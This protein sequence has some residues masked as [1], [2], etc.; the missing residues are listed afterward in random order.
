M[1]GT[2]TVKFYLNVDMTEDAFLNE[3]DS[4]LDFTTVSHYEVLEA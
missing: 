2:Y 1:Q 3:L 4:C